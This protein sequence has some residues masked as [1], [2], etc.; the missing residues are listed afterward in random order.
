MCTSYKC[1]QWCCPARAQRPEKL[2]M[3]MR[4]RK[5]CSVVNC[6][7]CKEDT[8]HA[9]RCSCHSNRAFLHSLAFLFRC[10]IHFV[11]STLCRLAYLEAQ[12][13]METGSSSPLDSVKAPYTEAQDLAIND[14]IY[15]RCGEVTDPLDLDNA[16]KVMRLMFLT[17]VL[18]PDQYSCLVWMLQKLNAR[19]N[20]RVNLDWLI[21]TIA[22]LRLDVFVCDVLRQ[23][24]RAARLYNAQLCRRFCQPYGP[25]HIT[26]EEAILQKRMRDRKAKARGRAATEAYARKRGDRNAPLYCTR[27]P[28]EETA[29]VRHSGSPVS[30][31]A[32]SQKNSVKPPRTSKSPGAGSGASEKNSRR[33]SRN[34]N[35]IGVRMQG[36]TPT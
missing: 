29:S 30:Q 26:E 1:G 25:V 3:V 8:R 33:V 24:A 23:D 4:E 32:S 18:Q 11:V 9:C 16:Y 2:M 6:M 20:G 22:M 31:T 35:S 5:C 13:L 28:I 12:T 17:P 36:G 21:Y 10:S 19:A 34:S 27:R 15:D 7:Y 14:S